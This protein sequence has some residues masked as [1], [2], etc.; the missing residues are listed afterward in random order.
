LNISYPK[1]IGQYNCT[2]FFSGVACR[3][4]GIVPLEAGHIVIFI[5]EGYVTDS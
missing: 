1:L 5:I 3:S 4:I 2:T